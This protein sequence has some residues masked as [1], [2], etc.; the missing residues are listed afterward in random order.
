MLL[1]H[2]LQDGVTLTSREPIS[3][4]SHTASLDVG[5]VSF[6]SDS[7]ST[8]VFVPSAGNHLFIHLRSSLFKT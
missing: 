7:G 5:T 8:G 3:T 1:S 2:F 4:T 6:S